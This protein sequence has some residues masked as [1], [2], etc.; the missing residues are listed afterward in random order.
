MQGFNKLIVVQ[1][2]RVQF[3]MILIEIYVQCNIL[4]INKHNNTMSLIVLMT[5]N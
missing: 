4:T 5:Q 3:S 1:L 2:I